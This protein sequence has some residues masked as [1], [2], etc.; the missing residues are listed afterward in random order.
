MDGA[1]LSEHGAGI[2]FHLTMPQLATSKWAEPLN[3]I[4]IGLPEA[5]TAADIRGNW[6]HVTGGSAPYRCANNAGHR[7][8][9]FMLYRP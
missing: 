1:G 9:C 3:L 4:S 5:Q 7:P 2:A 8:A 6:H